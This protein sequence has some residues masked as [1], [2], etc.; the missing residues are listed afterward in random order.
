MGWFS[1]KKK[2]NIFIAHYKGYSRAEYIGRAK[3][4]DFLNKVL[5]GT[6]FAEAS[7][8]SQVI[9]PSEYFD[10]IVC[11]DVTSN[12]PLKMRLAIAQYLHG[13]ESY[14]EYKKDSGG[15]PN[16]EDHTIFYFEPAD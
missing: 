9:F 10:E 12:I 6:E 7:S 13:T 11:D 16:E 14:V 2:Y 3:T 4:I 5:K 1:K 15:F 8:D